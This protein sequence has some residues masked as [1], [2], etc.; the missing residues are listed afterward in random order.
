MKAGKGKKLLEYF[1]WG[2]K[3]KNYSLRRQVARAITICCITAVTIQVLVMLTM[4]LNQYVSREK[5]DTLYLLESDN[6]KMDNAIQYLEEMALAIQH[7][8]GIKSFL[9]AEHFSKE[10]A[11]QQLK[12][13]ANL[14]SERNRTVSQEP[15][16]EMVYLFRFSGESIYNLYYPTLV[17]EIRNSNE[18]YR[19]MNERFREQKKAFYYE[20][21]E[22]E[23]N[24]CLNLY[25]EGMEPMGTC[26]F[27][28]NRAGIE[29]IYANVEKMEG[30]GW[31]IS[32]GEE[33]ILGSGNPRILKS[34]TMQHTLSTGFGLTL[35]AAVSHWQ[36]YR[37]LGTT[38]AIMLI[39][40][41]GIIL[42]S[43]LIGYT[44]AR[45]FV[46]PL[47]TVAEKIKLVG[48]GDFDTKLGEYQAEELNNI[49]RKFNEMTDYINVLVNEV[50]ET[51]LMAK[52]A[53]L[54]YLQAQMN[55]HFLFNVLSMIEMR[56]AINGDHEVREM[57]FKLSRL[58][59]GKIFRKGE[60]FIHLAE[61]LE[62]VEFYLSLQNSRFGDKITYSITY[63]GGRECY[64]HFLVPRLSIEPSVENAVCHGLE[65][66]GENGHISVR[67]F[68][69]KE[70]RMCILIQDNGVGFDLR[71]LD[72][73]G[74][75]RRHNHV[76]IN[77]TDRMIKNL[78][79][80]EYGLH[81][82]SKPGEGTRVI[83]SLPVKRAE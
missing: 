7:N 69:E 12:I 76:G 13:V 38:M 83:I 61:E 22:D 67:I 60:Y 45:I 47:E 50:Y 81:I 68:L 27:V 40:S 18:L 54:Q 20:V 1:L 9:T 43:A 2:R 32:Q 56:A 31:S 57:I 17:T 72:S 65:P 19:E 16:V 66:K 23:V 5:E 51:Q 42:L 30:Y 4:I 28:L 55:P 64:E 52:Q 14:F 82:E 11:A 46:R 44:A 29:E 48:K 37:S 71:L 58:Y 15:F 34:S 35:K 8:V 59:Q 79:G 26:I 73:P 49:S 36:I 63:A 41:G 21:W 77:N 80:E 10:S 25:D 6:A 24:L 33:H 62:I 78:C 39:I 74:Q 70:D 75:D 3:N 53:Q